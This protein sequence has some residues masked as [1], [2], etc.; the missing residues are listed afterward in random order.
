VNPIASAR[1]AITH[2]VRQSVSVGSRSAGTSLA[3]SEMD[4]ELWKEP[5]VIAAS[6]LLFIIARALYG[7]DRTTR[8]PPVVSYVVPW[9]GS[10]IELGKN[11]DAFFKRAMYVE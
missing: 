2:H 11:P 4:L 8:R 3:Y 10:A 5:K 6:V 1:S 7:K 9:V